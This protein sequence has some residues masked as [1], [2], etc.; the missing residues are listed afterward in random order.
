MVSGKC[1][2][3]SVKQLFAVLFGTKTIIF[4][5]NTVHLSFIVPLLQVLSPFWVHLSKSPCLLTY[6]I[7]ELLNLCLYL[8]LNR[9]RSGHGSSSP[10][11]LSFFSDQLSH[12]GLSASQPNSAPPRKIMGQVDKGLLKF[13]IL[14]RSE[15]RVSQTLCV[16]ENLPEDYKKTLDQ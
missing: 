13:K 3:T 1:W 14:Y 5:T 12:F 11:F 4:M 9:N 8:Q 2:V 16:A 15:S 10:S 7:S 6:N